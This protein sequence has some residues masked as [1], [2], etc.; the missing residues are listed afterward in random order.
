MASIPGQIIEE[1][2]ELGKTV[3]G[4]V[5]KTPKDIAG[6]AVESLGATSGGKSKAAAVASAGANQE[7]GKLAEFAA[8][9][10]LETKRAVARAALAELAAR[11]KPKEPAVWERHEQEEER[12][13]QQQT[14]AAAG[15][16]AAVLPDTGSKHP[17]GD[18]YGIKAKR[19]AAEM[20][21]NVRQD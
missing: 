18:L 7:P 10:S 8:A 15:A 19:G 6:R 9:G 4:E 12:K 11:P 16:A 5:V 21:R 2:G 20:S 17:K 1:L 13:R 14:Q 3:G